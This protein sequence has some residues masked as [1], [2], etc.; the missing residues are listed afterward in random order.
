MWCRGRGLPSRRPRHGVRTRL[1][2]F[3]FTGNADAPALLSSHAVAL[4]SKD[5]RHGGFQE[6]TTLKSTLTAHI[7]ARMAYEQAVVL[8]LA[9]NTAAAGLFQ[10]EHLALPLP[11]LSPSPTG[12]TLL[13][14]GGSSSVGTAAIQLARAAGLD[15]IA[16]ASKRNH[17]LCQS[18]GASHV[19]DY[20]DAG[21]VDHI[22]Q[23]LQGKKLAGVYDAISE[24]STLKTLVAVLEKLGGT[25]TIAS[26]LPGT[27]KYSTSSV[28]VKPG[29]QAPSPQTPRSSGAF[30][31]MSFA[32]QSSP[33]PSSTT[34][35]A[36]PY[37]AT[38]SPPPWRSGVSSPSPTR[39]SSARALR[40][41]RRRA[42]GARPA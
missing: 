38:S 27:D 37:G 25:H 30:A 18:L 8:P 23:A 19:F 15:V 5:N 10:K 22:V 24:E 29:R 6:Y 9:V 21:I 20:N 11:S 16:T 1:P 33:L 4:T 42:T 26:T 31:N 17:E 13:V 12:K 3:I 34:K 7:P 36:R 32:P 2:L 39:S 14:W 41:C 28:T 35:S 40:A